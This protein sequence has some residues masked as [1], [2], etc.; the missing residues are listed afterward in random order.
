MLSAQTAPRH[1]LQGQPQLFLDDELV[2]ERRDVSRCWHPLRKHPANPLFTRS[3]SETQ[4][5]LFGTVLREPEPGGDGEPIF[6]MWYYAVGENV[7]WVGYARSRDGLSWE[8]PELGL[9]PIGNDKAN[10]AVFAPPGW[11]LI[12]LSGVIR[13]PDPNVSEGERYKLILPADAGDTGA[14]ET[15]GKHFLTAVSP[16]GFRWHLKDSFHPPEP[17]Y[18]DRACFV[19]DPYQQRYALY[20]RSRSR[21]PELV[22]RGGP[23]YFGRAI[24]L[25]VSVDFESW[26]EEW[27]QVMQAEFNDPDGTEIY[28][29][30][31]FPCGGQWLALTQIHHSL[32]HLAYIDMSLSH[33]RDGRYWQRRK[34]TVLPVGEIG[35]WDRFNQCTSNHPLR[36]GD[37]IWVYYSGRLYRHKEYRGYEDWKPE[38][39][40]GDSGSSFV[41]IGLAT[42]RLDGWCSLQA[43]FGAG[44]IITQPVILP[45][46]DLWLN[47]G[48]KWG[49]IGVEILD[50]KEVP[51]PE[52]PPS[53]PVSADGVCLK[54]EWPDGYSSEQ[55]L[56]QP[57]RFRFTLEN[58][59]LYSWLVE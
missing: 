8:K 42:L 9:I 15:R 54:V 51:I 21:P 47:A 48:V 4:A 1:I 7:Q 27:P 56:G 10:N 5:F 37:E 34:E 3:G 57:V 28:G 31:A 20:A 2:A 6:R 45:R 16:D 11:R 14:E 22:A 49:K 52:V 55:L 17:C 44:T 24:G 23:N 38:I 40:R 50:E 46:G 36:V 18:P 29:W 39:K 59:H 35:E 43:G 41:G 12:G 53:H 58:G 19:R 13:D 30:S 26:A 33:S 25:G 32:P